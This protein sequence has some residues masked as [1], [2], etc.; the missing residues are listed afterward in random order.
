MLC[1]LVFVCLFGALF[2]R[3]SRNNCQEFCRCSA[4]D[5]LKRR[6]MLPKPPTHPFCLFVI[7]C[8]APIPTM[9]R[10][11]CT[12]SDAIF[13]ERA[14]FYLPSPARVQEM[15][16]DARVRWSAHECVFCILLYFMAGAFR[17]F[18]ACC[19]CVPRC[20][21]AAA[22]VSML[23]RR[24]ARDTINSRC[25][26]GEQPTHPFH[27]T[28]ISPPPNHSLNDGACFRHVTQ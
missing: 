5:V 21:C 18:V 27:H 6:T 7:Q 17:F 28:P 11:H 8:C 9:L 26:A 12:H 2:T 22:A 1:C 25:K 24:C 14:H 15:R 16:N 13:R 19:C 4:I 3:I 23:G 10:S 20:C